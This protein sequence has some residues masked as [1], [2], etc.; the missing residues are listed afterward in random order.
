M[1]LTNTTP[2]VAI[3]RALLAW[4]NG[5]MGAGKTVWAKTDYPKLSAPYATIE[6]IQLGNDTG[7]DERKVVDNG[8]VMETSYQGLR[9]MVVRVRVFT[10]PPNALADQW[11]SGLLQTLLLSLS[12][13]SVIDDF[14][15][16]P[17]AFMSHTP[18]AEAD[19]QEGD[20]WEWIAE[21]DLTLHYRSV[22][23]DDGL[24]AA[25]DD[26]GFVQRVEIQI[27]EEPPF[28]AD[29]IQVFTQDFSND[30]S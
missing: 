26:G 23:F 25:P 21:A 16:V 20:R 7:I 15:V 17:L 3:K 10:H 28:M 18:I 12:A 14:R 24:A 27:N 19:V 8:G 11:A 6:I 9:S 1:A 2:Y 13:Q 22:L 5:T 29:S 4:M 30:F